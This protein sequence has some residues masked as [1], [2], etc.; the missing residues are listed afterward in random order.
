MI[1]GDFSGLDVRG[2]HGIGAKKLR[3]MEEYT[4]PAELEYMRMI[5]RA[6]DPKNILNPGKIFNV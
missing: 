1:A 3:Y 4:E 2:E 6:V 5:K